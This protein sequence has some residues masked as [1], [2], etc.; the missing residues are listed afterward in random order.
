MP[1][2]QINIIGEAIL[3]LI[4]LFFT[5]ILSIPSFAAL[6]N[7][8]VIPNKPVVI[9][10]DST[11]SDGRILGGPWFHITARIQNTS[12]VTIR[13]SGLKFEVHSNIPGEASLIQVVHFPF[14]T[15]IVPGQ[16]FEEKVYIDSLM[17]TEGYVYQV[18]GSVVGQ[19]ESGDRNVAEPVDFVT[20]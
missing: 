12:D 1:S 9:T 4:A 14:M 2:Y 18:F 5:A 10:S 20:Q 8:E 15:V 3:K 19:G 11:M 6:A 13:L 16:I 17:P 7:F